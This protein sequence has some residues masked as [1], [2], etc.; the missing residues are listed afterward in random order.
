MF[1]DDESLYIYINIQAV[2]NIN[3][4]NINNV[5]TDQIDIVILMVKKM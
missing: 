3:S 2:S 1:V 4:H 5:C